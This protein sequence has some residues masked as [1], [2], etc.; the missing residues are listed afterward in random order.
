MAS[1]AFADPKGGVP[2]ARPGIGAAQGTGD[3]GPG[4][5]L[6]VPLLLP[7]GL[8]TSELDSTTRAAA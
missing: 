2:A 5:L 4:V 8:L 1:R 6:L 7:P 3:S